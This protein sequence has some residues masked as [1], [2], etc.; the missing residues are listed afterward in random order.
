MTGYR[1]LPMG[2]HDE[3]VMGGTAALAAF[4]RFVRAERALLSLLTAAIGEHETMLE[5]IRSARRG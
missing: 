4:E 2:R 1:N 3:Q 5:Q